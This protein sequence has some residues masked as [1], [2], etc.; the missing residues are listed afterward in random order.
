MSALYAE[1]A[2]YAETQLD[3][4]EVTNQ[5][6]PF[7]GFNG[8]SGDTPLREAVQREGGGWAA[9]K[10]DA[11]GAR[12]GD[13]DVQELARQANRHTPELRNFNRFGQRIDQV[14]FHPAWHEL[15]GIAYGHEVHSL[16]W[17]AKRDGAHVARGALSYLWN[18]IENGVGCPTGMS[19]AAVPALRLDPACAEEWESPSMSTEY[20][21]RPLPVAEKTGATVGMTLTEKQGGSDLRAN[22]TRAE[23]D[24]NG[25]YV[26]TGHK[27]FCSAPMSDVFFTLAYTGNGDDARPTCFLVPRSLPD[28]SR[29]RFFIQRLKDK[30]GNRSNAS[31]EVEF[32]RTRAQKLGE[33]GGGIKTAILMAHYTRMDFILG[34]AGLMRFALSHAIHHTAN[35][36][37]FQRT[38]IDQPLMAAVLADLALE[39]EAALVAGMRIAR[40]MDEAESDDGARLFQRLATSVIKYWVCKRA[41]TFVVEAL[42]CHGGNGFVEEGPMARLY[43]EAPLNGIWEGSGNVMCLDVVRAL[44]REPESRDAFFDEL[45]HSSGA[46]TRLD[47]YVTALK[48]DFD[49]LVATPAR[50]RELTERMAIAMQASLLRRNA[51]DAVA[52]TFAATRLNGGSGR[53]FG[54]LPTGVP[55]AA[56]V[57]RA[58][59]S[60]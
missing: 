5:P 21:P 12:V 50:G 6:P 47:T 8:Y 56:L 9:D 36:R 54:V 37:A 29:N 35:R 10:L 7:E 20:D 2:P 39:S 17:T 41:P 4:H 22:L 33:E 55:V 3:T 26:L 18:Q 40:A 57:E 59:I 34:S 49:E 30:C 48:T 43:R 44:T 11:L 1:T 28:G 45:D 53:Q 42:E 19:F 25:G 46:D 51:P 52:D 14:D 13:P 15:M 24:G 38:L 23:P 60:G 31:S 16:A 27:W 32:N 58:Q